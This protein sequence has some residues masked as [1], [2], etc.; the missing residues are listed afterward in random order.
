ML[1]YSPE[2]GAFHPSAVGRGTISGATGD[3]QAQPVALEIKVVT[4]K[5]PVVFTGTGQLSSDMK[6]FRLAGKL[7]AKLTCEAVR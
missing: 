2:R 7:G 6:T 1:P 3:F 5:Q 4:G